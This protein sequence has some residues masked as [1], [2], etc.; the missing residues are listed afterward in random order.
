M[1]TESI[2]CLKRLLLVCRH[3]LDGGFWNYVISDV[4]CADSVGLWC[5]FW[6]IYVES[7]HWAVQ[8]VQ[9]LLRLA[10]A[11]ALLLTVD[12]DGRVT[13]EEEVPVAL[14]QRGD[15]LK[16]PSPNAPD[17]MHT[18]A[19]T[20]RA[21][22]AFHPAF[23]KFSGTKTFSIY[24][25]IHKVQIVHTYRGAPNRRRRRSRPRPSRRSLN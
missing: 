19:H 9:K 13:A 15:L 8:A 16:V 6:S 3:I 2:T 12:G 4:A 17:G 25:K 10:P 24:R 7:A 20:C 1:L 18:C 5:C 11:T 21:F 22:L 23:R 14:V